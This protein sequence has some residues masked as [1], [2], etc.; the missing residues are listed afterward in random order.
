MADWKRKICPVWTRR[1][2]PT[3]K[4]RFS[5][6]VLTIQYNTNQ[7]YNAR[8]VTPKCESEAWP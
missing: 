8:K 3:R 7:I 6:T 1:Q 2:L 5:R 4:T